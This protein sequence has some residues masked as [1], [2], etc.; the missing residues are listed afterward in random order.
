MSKITSRFRPA[1]RMLI[2]RS[3]GFGRRPAH[4]K[5]VKMV[6]RGTYKVSLRDEQGRELSEPRVGKFQLIT[7]DRAL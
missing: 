3:T 1:D 6:P 5:L 4:G 2:R 7:L